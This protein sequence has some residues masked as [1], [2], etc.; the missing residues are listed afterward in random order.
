M[1]HFHGIN[2]YTSSTCLY[3]AVNVRSVCG[4]LS[5]VL[6]VDVVD[7]VDAV[8]AVGLFGSLPAAV[9]LAA[10]RW[11]AVAISSARL[12]TTASCSEVL[13]ASWRVLMDG[14]E[15]AAPIGAVELTASEVVSWTRSFA[16]P[17]AANGCTRLP[18]I[19]DC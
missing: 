13:A 4:S 12:D 18:R 14:C 8:D 19:V 10:A 9:D 11:A 3:S 7:A 1:I 15:V 6:S 2:T 5:V 16:C 17:A